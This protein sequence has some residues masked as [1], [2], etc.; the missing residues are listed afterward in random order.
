MQ[1]DCCGTWQHYH[2]YGFLHEHPGKNHFCYQ[3]LFEDVDKPR[4]EDLKRLAQFRR[5]LFVLYEEKPRSQS[6]LMKILGES[7]RQSVLGASHQSTE[8]DARAMRELVR[9]LKNEGFLRR[10][11]GTALQLVETAEQ[12]SILRRGYFDPMTYIGHEV[13]PLQVFDYPSADCVSMRWRSLLPRNSK[14]L[15]VSV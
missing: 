12:K 6:A 5:A 11:A 14:T 1:C 9:R 3:C 7:I 2:C 4:L 8:F 13:S 15:D 10:N